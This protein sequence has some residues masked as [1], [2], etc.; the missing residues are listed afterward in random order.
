MYAADAEHREISY[1]IGRMQV[2]TPILENRVGI[3]KE[4]LPND[5]VFHLVITSMI[6]ISYYFS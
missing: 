5:P 4:E 2:S 1:T 6:E 3:Q